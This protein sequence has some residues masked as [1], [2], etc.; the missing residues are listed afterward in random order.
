M[1]AF[2]ILGD[3]G[4]E[5]ES[6]DHHAHRRTFPLQ[7]ELEEM[8]GAAIRHWLLVVKPLALIGNA[9]AH[10]VANASDWGGPRHFRKGV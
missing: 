3:G 7:N 6:S 9:S 1:A 10:K 8:T 4:Y 2:Q 5:L